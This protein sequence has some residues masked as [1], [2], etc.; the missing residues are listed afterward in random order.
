MTV[1]GIKRETIKELFPTP[2]SLFLFARVAVWTLAAP[3]LLRVLSLPTLMKIVTPTTKPG[4]FQEEHLSKTD[5][6][7]TYVDAFLTKWNP[8]KTDKSCLRRSLVVYRFARLDGIPAHFC[9]GVKKKNGELKGHAWVEID[10]L[11]RYDPLEAE[12]YHR[13]FYYPGVEKEE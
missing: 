2:W 7:S 9:T 12:P 4:P 6:V 10:G 1:F 8:E 5:L 13:T 3:T 11:R